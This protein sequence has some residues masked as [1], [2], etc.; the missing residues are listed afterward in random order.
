MASETVR[1]TASLPVS[2]VKELKELA[3]MKK[4]PSVN[5]AINKAVDEYLRSRKAA[6]YAALMK[7]A[8]Q[9]KSL[10]ARTAKCAEGFEAVDSEVS[11]EW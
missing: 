2:C 10:L 4:I 7:E 5:Y 6:Q 11:G 3:K 1:Y 9:D 8:G